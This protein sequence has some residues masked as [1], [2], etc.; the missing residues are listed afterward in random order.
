MH[1]KELRYEKWAHEDK[2]R[3]SDAMLAMAIL[4]HLATLMKLGETVYDM[5]DDCASFFNQFRTRAEQ[6]PTT[7]FLIDDEKG[8]PEGLSWRKG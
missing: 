5:G 4:Q 1:P 8:K 7:T 6:Y 2:P 3:L